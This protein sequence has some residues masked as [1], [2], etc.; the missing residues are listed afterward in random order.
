MA[1]WVGWLMF[2]KTWANKVVSSS[3]IQSRILFS[4]WEP[5]KMQD[6]ITFYHKYPEGVGSAHVIQRLTLLKYQMNEYDSSISV[7]QVVLTA[8]SNSISVFPSKRD[9]C[10]WFC[11]AFLKTFTTPLSLETKLSPIA[12][13]PWIIFVWSGFICLKGVKLFSGEDL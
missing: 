7:T 5:S 6:H 2:W 12:F 3:N 8:L 10:F 4:I 13:I 11:H 9:L 1:H